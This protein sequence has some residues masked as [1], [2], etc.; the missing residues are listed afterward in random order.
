M[1][2]LL[3]YTATVSI[4]PVVDVV[5]SCYKRYNKNNLTFNDC[6]ALL[7]PESPLV[8][9]AAEKLLCTGVVEL[10]WDDPGTTG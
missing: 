10:L 3:L 1:N 7:H 5:T 4:T 6:D 2:R 8:G 9:T